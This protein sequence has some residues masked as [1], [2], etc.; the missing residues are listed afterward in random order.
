MKPGYN[1][2]KSDTGI[3]YCVPKIIFSD[4]TERELKNP[5]VFSFYDVDRYTQTVIWR[6]K[7][8]FDINW[9][10]PIEDI[11]MISFSQCEICEEGPIIV[12]GDNVSGVNVLCLHCGSEFE[13]TW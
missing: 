10:P 9:E 2:Y 7:R 11:G 1:Y 13:W 12:L 8:I 5:E 3:S 4:G 6:W